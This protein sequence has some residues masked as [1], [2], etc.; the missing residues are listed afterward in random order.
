[1]TEQDFW[2]LM[3]ISKFGWAEGIDLFKYYL[4]FESVFIIYEKE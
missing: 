1:M 2:L 3:Y 4:Q